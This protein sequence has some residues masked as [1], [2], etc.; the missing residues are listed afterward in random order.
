MK[1][2]LV[3]VLVASSVTVLGATDAAAQKAVS[4]SFS[5]A[6]ARA[7][8]DKYCVTCH[9]DRAKVAGLSLAKIDLQNPA[10]DAPTLERVVQKLQAA[11]MP[12]VGSPRPDPAT[13]QQLNRW[14]KSE[15]DRAASARPNAGRTEGLHRLNR[16][17]YQNVIRDLLDI[18]GLEIEKLLPTDDASYGFDNIAG[19]LAM[20]PTHVQRY[21]N[22]ARKISRLAV[23]DMTTAPTGESQVIALDLSQDSR[24]ESLPFGTRGGASVRR[25]FP[26]DG[27]YVVKF[28]TVAGFGVSAKEA[29]F[30]ELT[31]DGARAFYQKVEQRLVTGM[32][33]GNDED[34]STK[35]EVRL[36]IKAGV[37]TLAITFVQTTLAEPDEMLQPYLRPPSYSTF[38]IERLGGYAGPYVSRFSYTGP[39]NAASPGEGPSRKRIFVCSPSTASEETPCARRIL[40]KLAR[41][42]YRRPVSDSDGLLEFYSQGYRSGGF[43]KG[44][45]VALQQ[46]LSSPDF[47]FRIVR[48]P[49]N[50]KP[51]APYA[52]GDLDLASR[53][54]FF[55]WSSIP[56]D[57]LL[58][59]AE[60]GRLRQPAVLERQVRRM[61]KDPKAWALVD[62][63]A[64][65]WLRLRSLKTVLPET[66][67]FPDFDDNLRIGF[68]R[69][70]E[71]FFES[72]LKEDRS[73][74][75]LIGANYTFVNERLARHY[76]IPGIYGSGFRRVALTDGRR[77]GLLA[78]GSILVATAQPNRTS[79]V[80]RGKWILE[81][82]L[83]APPPA[84]PPNVPQLEDTPL[85]GTLRQRMEQH[86]RNPVCAAC[87]NVM[88][89]LGF[90]LENFDAVG[91]WRTHDNSAPVDA[92]G[93]L[94]DGT[95]F[96]G[97]AGLR[98]ALLS[99]PDLFVN[100]FVEKLMT[101]ALGRGIEWYDAPAIREIVRESAKT[102]YRFSS[103]VLGVVNSTPF[104]MRQA[105]SEVS[106]HD[107][108]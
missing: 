80:T 14:L 18:E 100:A 1:R 104:R 56:D 106:G 82:L 44:I 92:Q 65:Q 107:H 58:A 88:D 13:Y 49:S 15:L 59:V 77:G 34:M 9:N 62:S 87:H 21:L 78:Q 39:L 10:K 102:E 16:L 53:L 66:R 74:L 17:E 108:H 99:K 35:Y 60:A 72:I 43:E 69:E 2:R 3:A 24:L 71:L 98:Q 81:S 96:E 36:P 22:A 27:E 95:K 70:T 23:G 75:D 28:E 45:R 89:P 64:A 61:L 29:N 84:P 91:A 52:I 94:P 25:Y 90:A 79:P 19:V 8:V 37:R 5:S 54:S 55:L 101:Y 6:D 40:A 47:L 4:T 12:P 83:A 103:I 76:G 46:I 30:V 73:V 85:T 93:S 31:V 51:D 48:Q 50:A 11:S 97:V 20:S 42:A 105:E 57:E 86:R 33:G 7:T 38:K 32:S 67:M 68:R 41:R 26:V 63:F